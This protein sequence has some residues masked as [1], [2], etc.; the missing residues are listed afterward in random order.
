MSEHSELLHH[1]LKRSQI[2]IAAL[3]RNTWIEN[4][5][6]NIERAKMTSHVGRQLLPLEHF[7]SLAI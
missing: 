6:K 4:A 1:T 5:L 7:V 2:E 3:K